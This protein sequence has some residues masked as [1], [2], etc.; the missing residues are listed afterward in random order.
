MAKTGQMSANAQFTAAE[1]KEKHEK[2]LQDVEALIERNRATKLALM[3]AKE[4]AQAAYKAKPTKTNYRRMKAA[5]MR[6]I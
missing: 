2:H 3:T 5:A 1:L 4:Q 6:T